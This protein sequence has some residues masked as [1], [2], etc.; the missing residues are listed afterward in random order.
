LTNIVKIASGLNHSLAIDANG[1][2]WAWGDNEFG[3]LGDGSMEDDTNVPVHVLGMSNSVVGVA[4]GYN[5]SVAVKTDGTVWTWGYNASGQL[6][7]G[8]TDNTNIPVQVK[9]LP[10]NAVAVAAGYNHTLALLSDGTVWAWGG[11]FFN[12][13]GDGLGIESNTPVQVPNLT[14]IATICAGGNHNLALDTNGNVWAWGSFNL[15][16]SVSLI[17]FGPP[18][19]VGK[20]GTAN[21]EDNG[22]W[23]AM[24]AGLTNVIGLA[25]GASHSLV[26]DNEGRLWAWGSDVYGQLGDGGPD[27]N[28]G[29]YNADFPIQVMTNII[30]I[31][32]GSDASVALDVNGNV[33]QCGDSDGD[34]TPDGRYVSYWQWGDENSF[35]MMA[36][37]YVDFYNG[38]LPNLSILNGNNQTPH[39]GLEFEQTLVFRVTDTNGAA[40][41]NAPVSV[42][43]VAGDMEL[44]TIVVGDNYKG[45]RLTT[46]SNGEVTLIGYA[47]QDFSN[48]NCV[49][50]VLAASRERI[51][52]A[53]FN[54]TLVPPPTVN[55]T[56]PANGN[57]YLVETN[58]SLAVT[59]DA[60]AAPGTSIQEVDYYYQT[61][62]GDLMFLGASTQSP[63]S[64]T[65]TNALWWTNAFVGQYT[66]LAVAV[67]NAGVWS[68]TNSITV[69][70]ALD[71]VGDG[72]PDWWKLQY[73]GLISFSGTFLDAYANTLHYDYQNG[74]N[75]NDLDFALQSSG[76]VFNTSTADVT[77]AVLRGVPVYQAVLVNN[78]NCAATN[79]Q[80]GI[81]SNV[82]VSF[83]SGD[84]EYDVWV[85]LHGP[86]TNAQPVWREVIFMQNTVLPVITITAPVV[87]S[88]VSVPL[89]QVQGVANGP[90]NNIRYDVSNAAGVIT[91]QTGYVTS[92]FYDPN[93]LAFTTNYF[94]CYDVALTAGVNII[95]LHATDLAGN[96][97]TTNFNVT[98]DYSVNTTAPALTVI[99]PPDGAHISGSN[100]TLQAQVDDSTAQ[101]TAS[102]VDANGNTNTVQGLVERDG[103]VWVNNLPLAAGANTLTLTAT[104]AASNV[105]TTVLTLYQCSVLVTLDPLTG[106]QLN[107]SSV[108]VSGTVSDATVALTVNGVTAT[109]NPDGT[110][111]ADNVPVY[112][113]RTA[114]L[115]VEISS[116][117]HSP[118]LKRT[119]GKLL[120]P[121]D[122]A[123]SSNGSA[124]FA[125]PKPA[126]VVLESFHGHWSV[127]GYL[128]A[129]M[130]YDWWGPTGE[131]PE[132]DF[133][134][135]S[136]VDWTNGLGG[137]CTFN[138]TDYTLHN[139]PAEGSC[140]IPPGD[141]TSLYNTCG[142]G[143][144]Y[145]DVDGYNFVVFG[146]YIDAANHLQPQVMIQP[147]GQEVPGKTAIYL[148]RACAMECTD[149]GQ[150]FYPPGSDYH[151]GEAV[152]H[153]WYDGYGGVN[154][155]DHGDVP[156]PPE[157]LQI[158][159]Q[160]LVNTGQTNDYG[161]MWGATIVSAPAGKK[162]DVTPIATQL[163]D[164]N[165]YT[166]NV[167]ALDITHIW[168]VDNNRDGQIASD[169]GDATT[170]SKPFRFW[171]NDSKESGDD[172][173]AGGADDQIPGS[174]TPNYSW[175]HPQGRSDYVNFFP[176]ALCLSNLLQWL[177]VTNGFEYHLSQ[178]NGAVKIAYTD[179]TPTYALDYLTNSAAPNDYGAIAGYD[180]SFSPDSS[181]AISYTTL[182]AADLVH[183]TASGLVINTNW[184]AQVQIN[185]GTG[186][187]LVEG[188]A[189]TTKP[190]WLEI[191]RNGQKAGGVPL[192][193]SITGVEQMFRCLNLCNY[194]NGT[195]DLNAASRATITNEPPTN[196][197]NLVF[198]HGY[199][200]NQQQARGVESEMFKRF[201]WSGSHSKF[202][203]VTWNGAESKEN[204]YI[205]SLPL[206]WQFTPNFHTNVVNALQTAPHLADFLTNGLSGETTVA[207]HSLGNMVVLSAISDWSAIHIAN[208]FMI[209]AAV[210][211]ESVQGNTANEP[212][213]IHPNWQQDATGQPYHQRLY[214][215]DWWQLFTNDYRNTLTWSNRL[216]NLGSVDIYNFYSS[217]EEV[218]RKASGPIPA[219]IL[220]A[221]GLEI[222]N[223]YLSSI[224]VP[225][226]TYAWT[227][228][229]LG[230]GT[231]SSDTFIGSMHGG[232]SFNYYYYPNGVHM[233]A[234]DAYL[235]ADSQL[236]TNA[237]FDFSSDYNDGI[238]TVGGNIL[239]T[240][241][242]QADMALSLA[243]PGSLSAMAATI[244]AMSAHFYPV[245]LQPQYFYIGISGHCAMLSFIVARWFTFLTLWREPVGWLSSHSG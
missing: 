61:N 51:V 204:W 189:A 160:T 100:F 101:V 85:G 170:A 159:K 53:D 78:T 192:Y 227:W 225:L 243:T 26:L 4:S 10:T 49:V 202:Y 83:D 111:T 57:T 1:S 236:Q 200:V 168:A 235:L 197:K 93:L 19:V 12:Q 233:L 218:L 52:E 155:R 76:S 215:S 231:F 3:Q 47:D 179:L 40:L 232:W 32:A 13:L 105:S 113:G 90:L 196:G 36:P 146:N 68:D 117:N 187:I 220:G 147:Q 150:G 119:P 209:D 138:S 166:F 54:E 222:Y 120:A 24:V 184:L 238:E 201:Y 134:W 151:A 199:N 91:N 35:P 224:G 144:E 143:W 62:G 223:T 79:W 118:T 37:Q 180:P 92:Q 45:F 230:K 216:G 214:A 211:T 48:P 107:Q 135:S 80:F 163:Y 5:H 102:I 169:D 208:Y 63:F 125:L 183:V 174:S 28:G 228:Q 46:D 34:D 89:L 186:I 38:Q 244:P 30:A 21:A 139:E 29:Q 104:D 64:F 245:N 17:V 106:D 185:G 87:N 206:S 56:S 172:E 145:A 158:Q 103:T 157:W 58:Q 240:G 178:A 198:L 219:T 2:L 127:N 96:V 82:V 15:S 194:G 70:I 6:G 156:L 66:L 55:I 74:L 123:D 131:V 8:N 193:L 77:I 75:P 122:E 98:L 221:G 203:G 67:D 149:P 148:V 71:S 130:G 27:N 128:P 44:R 167:Q 42:E 31:A 133:S 188:C 84:G 110:W 115:D 121:S 43:V 217:G 137:S 50:R 136:T 173:S 171:I 195:V 191:W 97:T 41:S 73:V 11:D 226:G 237:F 94:Q 165:D 7:I 176:V 23:P 95:T 9:G 177:P 161:A 114:V 65:W 190:L 14:G 142:Y 81:S 152:S 109:V 20:F 126:V 207:A 242:D 153:W 239:G 164:Y 181:G 16:Q 162:V 154:G 241:S 140:Q 86:S 99:W 175:N 141:W 88:T 182:D 39:A 22:D 18:G 33:W 129:Y 212:T 234:S 69:T 210:P 116:F 205:Q 213:M 132:F 72:L 108:S 60:E 59:V 25:A 229:E 112:A 124:Q